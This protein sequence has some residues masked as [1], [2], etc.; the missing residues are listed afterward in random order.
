M[1]GVLWGLAWQWMCFICLT[2]NGKVPNMITSFWPWIAIAGGWW[3]IAH[4]KKAFQ[5]NKWPNACLVRQ[6]GT[7]WAFLQNFG[8][9]S[10]THSSVVE[11]H[12]FTY[13]VC[14]MRSGAVQS[15][16]QWWCEAGRATSSTLPAGAASLVKV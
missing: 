13:G 11:H 1:Y 4:C 15:Q 9:W 5:G 8:P 12:V 7:L 14:D 3:A 6:D 16:G 10:T 2:P